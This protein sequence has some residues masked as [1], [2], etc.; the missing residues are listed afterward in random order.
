MVLYPSP[1][2]YRVVPS[3]FY[4]LDCTVFFGTNT[5]LNAYARKA[6]PYDFR[7]LRYV[8]AGAERLQEA[9][10]ALWMRNFGARILE[11]YGATECGPCLTVNLPMRPRPGSV[12]QFLPGIEYRLEEVE[13]VSDVKSEIR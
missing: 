10:T 8:F 7:T 6:H 5:F 9:T 4:N 1:L 13:G 2:H 12:G 11:G 3:A